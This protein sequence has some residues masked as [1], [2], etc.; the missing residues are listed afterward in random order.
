MLHVYNRK[1]RDGAISPGKKNSGGSGLHHNL[2]DTNKRMG[3]SLGMGRSSHERVNT[4]ECHSS[5]LFSRNKLF[6][7][8]FL[9]INLSLPPVF[10]VIQHVLGIN[11]TQPWAKHTETCI[12]V[13]IYGMK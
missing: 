10:G 13:Y 12:H 5:V 4:G 2:C 9:G 6:D 3:G 11:L 1:S 8:Y 7:H